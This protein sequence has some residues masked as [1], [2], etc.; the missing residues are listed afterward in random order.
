LV[1]TGTNFYTVGYSATAS[2]AGYD[3]S[4][5]VVDSATQATATFEGGVPITSAT[6]QSRDDRAGLRFKLDSSPDQ[7]YQAVNTGGAD[8]NMIKNFVNPF[9]LTS[10]SSGLSCSFNGGCELQMQGTAGV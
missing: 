8:D 5:V 2:Y 3:A 1:Y 10:S 6:N 4:S 7:V 9:S